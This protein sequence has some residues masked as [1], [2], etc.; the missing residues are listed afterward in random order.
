M[1]FNAEHNFTL[2]YPVLLSPLRVQDTEDTILRKARVG[3]AYL[4]IL[5]HR[6]FGPQ[7]MA[8]SAAWATSMSC[9]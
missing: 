7:A 8:V 9:R 4:D 2:Q 5:I 3:A 6:R 1:C